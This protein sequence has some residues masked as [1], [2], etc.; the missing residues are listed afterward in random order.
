MMTLSEFIYLFLTTYKASKLL[1]LIFLALSSGL[2]SHGHIMSKSS[3]IYM[4]LTKTK[5]AAE[6]YGKRDVHIR[7][8]VPIV[9]F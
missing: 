7:S 1:F 4:Q 9:C 2:S 6:I 8:G 5:S 3:H